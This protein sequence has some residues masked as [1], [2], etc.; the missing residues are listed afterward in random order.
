MPGGE[1]WEGIWS[2]LMAEDVT[3]AC[4]AL[5]NFNFFQKETNPCLNK[6]A[7]YPQE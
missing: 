2:V 6:T 7:T 1:Y 4:V 3:K 5:Q